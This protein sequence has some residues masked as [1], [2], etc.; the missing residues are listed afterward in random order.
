VATTVGGLFALMPPVILVGAAIW[1]VVF[2][3]WKYVSLASLALGVSL[4]L[5]A[6][7]FYDDPRAVG[8][9]VFLTVLIIVRHRS[10][11]QRLLA[12]TENRAGGKPS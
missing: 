12:G 1:L 10:N 7:I 3:I 4:P 6:W 2:F 8:F 9:C 11:I 5:S